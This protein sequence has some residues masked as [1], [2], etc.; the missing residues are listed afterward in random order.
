MVFFSGVSNTMAR[1]CCLRDDAD[2]ADGVL[3]VL[4]LLLLL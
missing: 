4:L 3:L 2:A 1:R